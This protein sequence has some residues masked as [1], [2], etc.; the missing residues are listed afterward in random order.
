MSFKRS[1]RLLASAATTAGL[2]F[3]GLSLAAPAADAATPAA[4]ASYTCTTPL[5][6]PLATFQVPA[7][8]SL[9]NL[10]SVLTANLPVPAGTPL[11]GTLDFSATGLVPSLILALQQT[12]N[13]VVGNIPGAGSAVTPLNGLFSQLSGAAATLTTQLGSFTPS[14]GTLPLPIPTSFDFAPVAGLLSGLGVHCTLNKG[15]VVT[16]PGGA[17]VV[18]KQGASIKAHAKKVIHHGQKAVVTVKVKTTGGQQGVGSIVAK[19]KG[20]KAK[21]KALKNGKVRIVLKGLKLGK[22]KIKLRFLGNA[23]TNAAKGKVSVRVVR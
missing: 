13:L 1:T 3:G 23:Y 11:V 17:V 5:P 7:N 20:L 2:A 10:P 8:F 16:A 12:V 18:Q 14:A 9:Q 21:T 15:S 6:G 19:A 22:N 4:S